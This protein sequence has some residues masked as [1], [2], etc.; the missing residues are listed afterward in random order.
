[1][2]PIEL[3]AEKDSS[4]T[5]KTASLSFDKRNQKQETE[6]KLN[7]SMINVNKYTFLSTRE[8][9]MA[10][11]STVFCLYAT[12]SPTLSKIHFKNWERKHVKVHC[13]LPLFANP[14]PTLSKS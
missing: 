14:S 9:M 6:R 4:F 12:P 5:F 2:A 11:Y 10:V 13:V 1:M 3:Y 7:L 8:V